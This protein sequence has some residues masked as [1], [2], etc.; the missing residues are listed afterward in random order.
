MDFELTCRVSTLFFFSLA[1][2]I[3]D[4]VLVMCS[5]FGLN[6]NGI[7]VFVVSFWKR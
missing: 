6:A 1:G 4:S 7:I 2:M 3:V 5:L